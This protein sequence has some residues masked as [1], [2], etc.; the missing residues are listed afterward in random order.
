MKL[1]EMRGD[2]ALDVLADIIE[3]AVEIMQDKKIATAAKA[4]KTL[5]VVKIICKHH[6]KSITTIMAVM[7]DK[8]PDTYEV[9]VLTLPK[10]IL[11]LINDPE[12]QMLFTSPPS[13]EAKKRSGKQSENIKDPE[14]Q[15]TSS[16]TP[17]EN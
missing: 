13:K 1:S 7:E 8:D 10:M 9:G 11:D 5:D 15:N 16:D 12:I 3:P 4:G 2:K 14:E 6:K 17:Q